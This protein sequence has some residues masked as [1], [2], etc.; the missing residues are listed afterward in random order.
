MFS[1]ALHSFV[2]GGRLNNML[3]W[4][5]DSL[6]RQGRLDTPFHISLVINCCL[7][8]GLLEHRAHSTASCVVIMH[9]SRIV[10]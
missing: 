8:H 7:N 3:P 1:I 2:L 9:Q 10:T 5:Y 6:R 4:L